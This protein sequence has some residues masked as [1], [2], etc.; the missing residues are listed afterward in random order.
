MAMNNLLAVTAVLEGITGLSLVLYPTLV[1]WLLFGTEIAGAGLLAS[2]F[3]G[4]ILIA[5]SVAC[6][7][8]R[9]ADGKATHALGGMLTYSV[10]ATIYLGYVAIAGEFVGPLLWPAV[11]AHALLSTLLARSVKSAR[12]VSA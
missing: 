10:F 7:P 5:L 12:S 8:G 11:V 2:R 9:D 4:V 6:W 1:V 3:A